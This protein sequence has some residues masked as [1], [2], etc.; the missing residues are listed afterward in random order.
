MKFTTQPGTHPDAEILAAFSEQLV[1]ETERE[2]ILAHMATCDRCREVVFLAQIAM[3]AGEPAPVLPQAPERKRFGSRFAN[4][5]FAWIPVAAM[6]GVVGFAVV[7][8]MRHAPAPEMR[9]AQNAAP[10]EMIQRQVDSKKVESP[11]PSS[12]RSREEL[13]SK[14]IAPARR[15]RDAEEDQ[16]SLDAKDAPAASQKKD[17]MATQADSLKA[18]VPPAATGGAARG[19]FEARAKSSSIGGPLAQNQMQVQNSA[20]MQQN[21]ANEAKERSALSDSANKPTA[22]PAKP[23]AATGTVI[24]QAQGGIVP[25]SPTPEANAAQTETA[26]VLLSEKGLSKQKAAESALPSNLG[27]LSEAVVGTK[28]VAI[29]TAGS[30]FVSRDNGKGWEPVKTQWNGRAVLVKVKPLSGQVTGNVLSQQP[31]QFELL[32]DKLDTWISTDGRIWSLKPPI[33]NK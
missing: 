14:S 17:E 22:P 1:T 7:E 30:V 33:T 8:H 27:V 25:A 31:A 3:E 9:M 26:T 24:V 29:D 18:A 20:Q 16:R 4:W 10:A 32:T 15:D 19:T 28:T 5:R 23:G 6:A 11:K 21:Y 12:Q 2:E 13:K